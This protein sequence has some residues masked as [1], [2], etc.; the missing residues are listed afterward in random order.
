M[1][2]K[3]VLWNSV[4][5]SSE[6]QLKHIHPNDDLCSNCNEKPRISTRW[7][8]LGKLFSE[9]I[10]QDCHCCLKQ[11]IPVFSRTAA[12]WRD[13]VGWSGDESFVKPSSL[14]LSISFPY[15]LLILLLKNTAVVLTFELGLQHYG[16]IPMTYGE[17]FVLLI[18]N[19]NKR[20]SSPFILILYLL[21]RANSSVS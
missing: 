19:I 8:P 15:P 18:I 13:G 16:G 11:L 10:P 1:I 20:T 6:V 21:D 7:V 17:L 4:S 14:R 9:F 5:S 3:R 2:L 12:E